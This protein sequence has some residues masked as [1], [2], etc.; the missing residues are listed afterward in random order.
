MQARHTIKFEFFFLFLSP[1]PGDSFQT[2]EK[3]DVISQV[4]V[5]V[6]SMKRRHKEMQILIV[7]PNNV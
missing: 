4:F 6:T 2:L 5:I 3:R 7:I 1:L